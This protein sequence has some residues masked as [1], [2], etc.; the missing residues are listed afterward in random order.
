MRKANVKWWEAVDM[1]I[2]TS[3]LTRLESGYSPGPRSYRRRFLCPWCGWKGATETFLNGVNI[4]SRKTWTPPLT[5]RCPKCGLDLRETDSTYLAQLI[6]L[7]R[8]RGRTRGH[9]ITN[10]YV[11]HL[12]HVAI[13][14]GA[15]APH[16]PTIEPVDRGGSLCW[17]RIDRD[18]T[19]PQNI[20]AVYG[21]LTQ[22]AAAT[23]SQHR[24][25]VAAQM[26]EPISNAVTKLLNSRGHPRTPN[27][28][29]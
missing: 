28:V 13:R 15:E 11:G 6:T 5:I 8:K 1:G 7:V 27:I 4:Q 21:T 22:A 20:G 14:S 23:A 26:Y 3:A 12:M 17:K 18:T 19:A 25:I 10:E 16:W 9:K 2:T 24:E 29:T